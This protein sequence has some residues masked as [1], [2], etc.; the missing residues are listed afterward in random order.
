[1]TLKH[2]VPSIDSQ[3]VPVLIVTTS[4]FW[5]HCCRASGN[6]RAAAI[7]ITTSTT[8]P[9]SMTTTGDH[10]SITLQF[11]PSSLF[12]AISCT[13]GHHAAFTCLHTS[14]HCRATFAFSVGEW[15]DTWKTKLRQQQQRFLFTCT[16]PNNAGHRGTTPHYTT[17][18]NWHEAIN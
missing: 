14:Y 2:F 11:F 3:E 4:W 7:T 10:H 17:T 9:T 12:R 1:M 8:T 15:A 6:H 5:L 13:A 16:E 18:A